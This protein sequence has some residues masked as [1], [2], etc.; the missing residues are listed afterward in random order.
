MNSFLVMT[1]C[2]ENFQ[3]PQHILKNVSCLFYIVQDDG[4]LHTTCGTPYYVAPEVMLENVQT[5]SI[6]D[7]TAITI[8]LGIQWL[9]Y[10][11]QLHSRSLQAKAMT[12]QWLMC[13]HV[14]LSCLLCLQGICH[15]RTLILWCWLRKW[16]LC[17]FQIICCSVAY[18]CL[19]NFSL[20]FLADFKCRICMS[21]V[22]IFSCQEVVKNNSWSKFNDGMP[23][24]K[25][26]L[27]E[28]TSETMLT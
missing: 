27:K 20:L 1:G 10:F 24:H 3:T 15:L 9:K 26:C 12:V 7:V 8:S 2:F 17:G 28:N 25:S 4:L 6:L 23:G 13:G 19:F 22:D 16:A 11:Y 18:L 5:D 21:T 14:E